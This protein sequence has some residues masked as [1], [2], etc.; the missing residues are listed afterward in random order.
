LLQ[1]LDWV[2]ARVACSGRHLTQVG[3]D[4]TNA[5]G[6]VSSALATSLAEGLEDVLVGPP[7]PDPSR[8]KKRVTPTEMAMTKSTATAISSHFKPLF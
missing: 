5:T 2:V 7:P 4:A 1:P 6:A 3:S 8:V